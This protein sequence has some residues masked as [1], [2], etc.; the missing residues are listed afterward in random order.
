MLLRHLLIG[1]FAFF[2]VELKRPRITDHPQ[3]VS[4]EHVYED[5]KKKKKEFVQR[6]GKRKVRPNTR[7]P[8]PKHLSSRPLSHRFSNQK[9]L[10]RMYR[11]C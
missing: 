1:L 5:R 8:I 6:K 11:N 3:G 10:R 2:A 4:I 9:S 7:I